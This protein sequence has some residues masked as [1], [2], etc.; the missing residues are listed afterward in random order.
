MTRFTNIATKSVKKISE[1]P[2]N[3]DPIL[4]V[5]I[6][7]ELTRSYDSAA[8][9]GN[10]GFSFYTIQFWFYC[11]E[12]TYMLKLCT[13]FLKDLQANFSTLV[14]VVSKFVSVIN[15]LIWGP[16]K[17]PSFNFAS[18]SCGNDWHTYLKHS[19]SLF[20]AFTN[21][22]INP[23]LICRGGNKI[24]SRGTSALN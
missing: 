20:K 19:L 8:L 17:M 5:G 6:N 21:C 9:R 12:V 2:I 22:L 4:F 23:S 24:F 11:F 3:S 18:K 16:T 10:F 14:I 7:S 15:V 1:D 13:T